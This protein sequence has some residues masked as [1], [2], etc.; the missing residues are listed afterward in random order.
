MKKYLILVATVFILFSCKKT[1]LITYEGEN[2]ILFGVDEDLKTSKGVDSLMLNFTK[3]DDTI[4]FMT[5]KIPV[6]RMGIPQNSEVSYNIHVNKQLSNAV[7]GQDF[8]IADHSSFKAN[9][10]TDS[11]ELK[12]VR[13]KN[14]ATGT[15]KIVLELDS[16]S[17]IN[18][19][20]PLV[21]SNT[22]SNRLIIYMT[23]YIDP[24]E[25]WSTLYFGK[26][27]AKKIRLMVKLDN[28]W[29][30]EDVYDF[31]YYYPDYFG[32]ILYNYLKKQKDAG[33][34]VLEADGTPMD[35][36]AFFN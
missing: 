13:S 9:L 31:A 18:K 32:E 16:S 26:F 6:F 3:L 20:Y 34:P 10:S 8:F 22:L 12:I 2:V 36:G 24:P 35:W 4:G 27:S 30:F 15:K 23:D 28:D 19:Q 17:K 25:K 11:V 29:P 33:T 1:E 21:N 7:Q 14:L 5:F